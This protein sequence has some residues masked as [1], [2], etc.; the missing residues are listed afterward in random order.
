MFDPLL[1]LAAVWSLAKNL[2]SNFKVA[3]VPHPDASSCETLGSRPSTNVHRVPGERFVHWPNQ[4]G[5]NG[6]VC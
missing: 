2:Q 3:I 5:A 6:I 1:A 4:V